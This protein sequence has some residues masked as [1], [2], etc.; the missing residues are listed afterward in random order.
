MVNH[1]LASEYGKWYFNSYTDYVK[2]QF[3]SV[4]A[5]Q[6]SSSAWT[7]TIKLMFSNLPSRML[8]QI[9]E[10]DEHNASIWIVKNMVLFIY[11]LCAGTSS[12]C[13][14]SWSF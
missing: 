2:E 8:G 7:V 10:L 3:P 13:K 5:A 14:R 11:V 6:A 4:V 12:T 9:A 1:C